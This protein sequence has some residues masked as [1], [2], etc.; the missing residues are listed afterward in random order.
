MILYPAVDILD[1]QAV[2]LVQGDFD[3]RTVYRDS[4]L[5]A[6]RAWV[7]A[8]A[9]FLHVVDLD[10][11]KSGA[12]AN[13]EHVAAMTREL[14]VPV[15]IGGGLRSLAVGPRGAGRRCRARDPRA[16]PR[17]ATSTCSTTASERSASA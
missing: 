14:A 16:P 3:D 1:G 5:E 9:R 15:Q 8:G 7:E 11:A 17:C 10:G 2:R 6:A 4:P 13:L 12:P